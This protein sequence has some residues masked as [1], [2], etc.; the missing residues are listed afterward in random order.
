MRTIGIY[1]NDF[2]VFHDIVTLLKERDVEFFSLRSGRI[3]PWITVV[4]TTEEMKEDIRF[5]HVILVDEGNV[6]AAVDEAILWLTDPKRYHKLIIGIDPGEKPGVAVYGDRG[7]LTTAKVELP[8]D[9]AAVV[10][11]MRDFYR[12][13]KV[14][15]RI[16]HGAPTFRNRIINTI[17][18][19]NVTIEIV[20]ERSTTSQHPTPDIQAAKRIGMKEGREVNQPMMVSPSKGEID[21]IKRRSRLLSEGRFTISSDKAEAVARGEMTLEEAVEKARVQLFHSAKEE[22]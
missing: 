14:I 6:E 16:G 8:E 20:D 21:D 18:P 22:E 19:L 17:L 3:P 1:T 7:L 2:S 9:T 10:K 15:V 4:L 11:R 5:S 13:G 12:A